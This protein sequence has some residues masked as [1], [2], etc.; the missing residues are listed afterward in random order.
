MIVKAHGTRWNNCAPPLCGTAWPSSSRPTT[1]TGPAWW[2]WP[3]HPYGRGRG[4]RL[5]VRLGDLYAFANAA[6][7]ITN[8]AA[9]IVDPLGRIL[10]Y[11]TLP[12]QPIDELRRDHHALP[13][14]DH[15]TGV[16]P[17]FQD[18]L[19]SPGR[20]WSRQLDDGMD[21]LALAVRAGGELLGS[22]WIIDPGEEQREAALVALDRM[23]PLAGLH[24]LHARSASDF[25]ER[26]NADLIR[27]LM[28][29]TPTPPLPPPSSG[30]SRQRACGR[31]LFDRSAR[32]RKP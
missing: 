18:R 25:G 11:S 21:R 20:C 12:G 19:A 14:G 28:D 2:H 32:N 23:A 6:A 3:G 1:R 26:R 8:G 10:G 9:S 27:T 15:A 5:G 24:M 30:S 4:F 13:A 16:R 29:D 22:I 31:S 7:S 17:G